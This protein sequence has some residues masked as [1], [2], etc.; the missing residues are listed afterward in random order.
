MN[1]KSQMGVGLVEIMVAVTVSLLLLAG[2]VRIL[3]G[4][5][6]TFQAQN[7]LQGLQEDTRA[8]ITM[9]S[10]VIA[11][12]GFHVNPLA[13]PA[14]LFDP[15]NNDVD[16]LGNAVIDGE[17]SGANPHAAPDRFTVSFQSDGSMFDCLGD[18]YGPGSA[19]PLATPANLAFVRN[20]FDLNGGALRCSVTVTS[21]LG[22]AAPIPQPLVNNVESM[23]VRYGVDTNLD[24]SVDQYLWAEE[25]NALGQWENVRAIKLALLIASEDAVRSVAET[26]PLSFSLLGAPLAVADDRRARHVI[27]RV[28]ALNNRLHQTN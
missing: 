10:D 22:T 16:D 13:D 8:A 21:A 1:R 15:A 5:K 19:T 12:A 20:T 23:A 25:V 28:I 26:N 4:N 7:M 11:N 27:T 24:E 2:M 9:L 3:I 14:E 18:T 6:Q 17:A